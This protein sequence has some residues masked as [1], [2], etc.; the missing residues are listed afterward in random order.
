MTAQ[1]RS[2]TVQIRECRR[3]DCR[4]RYPVA[5]FPEPREACPRCGGPTRLLAYPQPSAQA[6]AAD[7]P[8]APPFPLVALLD[9]IRSAYNVG[10]IFRTADGAGVSHLHLCGITPTPAHP[11]VAKTALGAEDSL[12]WSSHANGLDAAR[13]LAAQGC[14][15]WALENGPKAT[16][17][18]QL[19]P[20]GGPDPLVL[21]VGNEISGV[22]P[23]ILALCQ[24]QVALPMAGIKG[25]LNVAVAFGVAVYWLAFGGGGEGR[26]AGR[27]QEKTAEKTEEKTEEKRKEKR[28]GK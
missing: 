4:F 6:S 10:A 13:E 24:R 28:E 15:L 8:A 21:V 16:P 14:V 9:N 23:A 18:F 22:D 20:P 1:P 3:P 11:R 26:A 12:A 25:S 5:A 27:Q 19:P 2:P 17:L 7:A